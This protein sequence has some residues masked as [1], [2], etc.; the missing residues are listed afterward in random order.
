MYAELTGDSE[1]YGIKSLYGNKLIIA[2]QRAA[3]TPM[4]LTKQNLYQSIEDLGRIY[5]DH[6]RVF[7]GKRYVQ[8]KFVSK[9]QQVP[10]GMNLDDLT[11]NTPFD[12]SV[13]DEIPL[14]LKLDVGA[15]A[16]W[17]EVAS[18]QT[19]DNLLM[20]NKIGIVDYLERVPN[21]YITKKQELLEKIK[22]SQGAA[23]AAQDG[24]SGPI[25]DTNQ[26]MEVVGGKGNG[27]LQRAINKTG[28][29][30]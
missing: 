3:N 21:G 18:M 16:Y 14:S 10:L 20:Q 22:A 23:T 9:D 24:A 12:F 1:K 27:A 25:L 30:R 2:L 15:S 19:L 13:L 5:I 8:V 7:Y 6:M 28:V 26:P 17:S 11:Y 29:T 4:E